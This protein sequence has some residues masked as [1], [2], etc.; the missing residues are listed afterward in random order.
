MKPVQHP[1]V[2]TVLSLFNDFS[3]IRSEVLAAAA[4]RGSRVHA[5]CAAHARG[6]WADC[7][8]RPE[9]KG[10]FKSFLSWADRAVTEFKAVEIELI[11]AKFGYMGHPDAIVRL[12][13]ESRLTVIDYKTP[14]NISRSWHPQIAAYAKL[15]K[16]QN[17]DVRRG[18]AVRLR[19]NGGR[20]IT[21]EIDIDGEP[22]AAFLNALGAY[23]YF[24]G[25]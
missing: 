16:A 15:A 24:K 17:Y 18:L 20:A 3:G 13:G 2:T 5:A 1:S 8:L 21:T 9:D 22:W 12:N 19:K 25:R 23:R 10:F 11:N 14:M 4:A 6:L 7:F